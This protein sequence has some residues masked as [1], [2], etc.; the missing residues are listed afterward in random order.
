MCKRGRITYLASGLALVLALPL[1]A[2]I[3]AQSDTVQ[4]LA[5]KAG[6][7][8]KYDK[9]EGQTTLRGDKNEVKG[10]AFSLGPSID[11]RI[12]CQG[13]GTTIDAA[14]MLCGL[15]FIAEGGIDWAF[16]SSPEVTLLGDDSLRVRLGESHDLDLS[17]AGGIKAQSVAVALPVKDLIRLARA[18]HIIGRIGK[19][20]FKFGGWSM[21]ELKALA[22]ILQLSQGSDGP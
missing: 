12:A 10:N 9:I 7:S 6:L 22:A 17:A 18:Q 2:Q 14:T 16:S 19:H 3:T 13:E 5:K 8:V 21:K 1:H 4:A 11:M 15:G 20:E